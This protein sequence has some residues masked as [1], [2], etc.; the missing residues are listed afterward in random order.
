MK[1]KMFSLM[2]TVVLSVSLFAG[3]GQSSGGESSNIGTGAGSN[4]GT[5]NVA[6][7]ESITFP[8]A[9]PVTL[10]MWAGSLHDTLTNLVT[11]YGDT[12]FYK[13]LE[14]R[15]N[16]HLEILTASP[17]GIQEAFNLMITSGD[18]PDI[19]L[20][21]ALYSRGLDAGVED[22]YFL[23]LNPYLEQ[24]M[25]NY[26]AKIQA[27]EELRRDSVTAAGRTVS[28]Q[29]IK[30]SLEPLYLGLAIR[31]DWLDEDNLEIPETI[32]EWETVLMSFKENHGAIAPLALVPSYNLFIQGFNATTDYMVVDGQVIYGPTSDNMKEALTVFADWYQKGLID[33]DFMSKSFSYGG[34]AAMILS[35]QCGAFNMY[36]TLLDYYNAAAEDSSMEIVAVNPPISADG[37]ESKLATPTARLG[38]SAGAAVSTQCEHPEIAMAFLDY[39][40]S[41]EGALLANYGIEGD[42]FEYVDGKPV[43]TEKVTNNPDGLSFSQTLSLYTCPSSNLSFY[44][45]WTRSNGGVSQKALDMCTVWDSVSSDY[46]YPGQAVMTSEENSEYAGIFS[47]INTY[48]NS[49]ISSFISG[50]KDINTEWKDYVSTVEGMKI[51]RCVELKQTAYDRYMSR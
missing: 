28:I 9:E 15:T 50:E 49:A 47:D 25:P 37:S 27:D 6:T 48:V 7:E 5:I 43:F 32:D 1:K 45:D 46:Y 18:L 29:T 23:D 8:L 26:Y 42:T 34:D 24:Y 22:G 12:D 4:G 3:C 31:K 13:E 16:V 21:P 51:G 20:A 30:Q 17:T 39:L 36:Y 38:G 44:D 2:M 14:K 10:T 19:I 33:Q 41:D 40:F 35:G 11:D